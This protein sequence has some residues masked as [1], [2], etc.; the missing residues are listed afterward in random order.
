MGCMW[1]SCLVLMPGA[2]AGDAAP[3]LPLHRKCNGSSEYTCFGRYLAGLS[4]NQL[5]GI[6][7]WIGSLFVNFHSTHSVR[8][9]DGGGGGAQE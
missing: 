9:T 3:S 8:L 5:L 1:A 2:G 7:H 6:F 4:E